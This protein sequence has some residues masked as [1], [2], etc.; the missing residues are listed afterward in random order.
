MNMLRPRQVF[1]NGPHIIHFLNAH[2]TD[3]DVS[4]KVLNHSVWNL[5]C[6][7]FAN[8]DAIARPRACSGRSN[9]WGMG[10]AADWTSRAN[11]KFNAP[12][13]A[14]FVASPPP[15]GDPLLLV[16]GGASVRARSASCPPHPQPGFMPC[17]FLSTRWMMRV[18]MAGSHDCG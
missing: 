13:E 1:L 16:F 17:K 18:C 11:L 9:G 3:S 8:A 14:G 15:P 12:A 5:F 6:Q 10:V 2:L 7:L 4:L